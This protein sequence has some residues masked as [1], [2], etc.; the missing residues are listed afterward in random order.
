MMLMML[1]MMMDSLGLELGR[2]VFERLLLFRRELAP[3]L[4]AFDRELGD[5]QL[6]LGVFRAARLGR[7]LGEHLDTLL[8]DEDEV[9]TSR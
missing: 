4:G 5:A 7:V 8:A 3:I 6:L 2:A 9:P 1:M